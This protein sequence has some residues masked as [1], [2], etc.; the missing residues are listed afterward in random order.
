MRHDA[1]AER[2]RRFTHELGHAT[3][4]SARLYLV[5]GAS[6]VLEQ[7]RETTIDIDLRLEPDDDLLLRAI[8]RLKE[9]LAVNVELAS[10]LDF[11]P[12]LPGW[13]ERSPFLYRDGTIDVFHLDFASQALAKLERGFEQDLADVASMVAAGVVD[14]AELQALYDVI[15]DELFRWPAVDPPSLRAAVER[16]AG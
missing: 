13:R 8:T 7:W 5:G 16:L 3:N 10:P 9:R 11:L 15:E 14:P 6:A 12:E 2:I 1:D 4:V